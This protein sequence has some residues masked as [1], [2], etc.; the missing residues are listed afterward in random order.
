MSNAETQRR[1]VPISGGGSFRGGVH[2]TEYKELTENAAIKRLVPMKDLVFPVVPPM[3]APCD[4]ILVKPKQE[5][6]A[7]EKIADASAFVATP[8]HSSVNGAVKAIEYRLMPSG[9]MVRSIVITPE[10]LDY[11]PP[12]SR[13]IEEVLGMNKAAIVKEVREAGIVG[14]GG[15]AF[16]THVKLS[17]PKDRDIDVLIINGC[18]CEPYLTADYRIMLERSEDVVAGTRILMKALGVT[19]AIIAVEDNKPKALAELAAAVPA[20]EGIEVLRLKTL[21]PQGAEKNL[22]F[23]A[24]HRTVPTGGLP[25]DSGVVVQNVTTAVAVTDALLTGEPLLRKP[26]TITGL[27]LAEPGNYR[28]PIG[29]TIA[30]IME[31]LGGTGKGVNKI[32]FGGPMMGM[33]L[34]SIDVPVLKATSGV[35]FARPEDVHFYRDGTCIRCSKCVDHCPMNLVPTELAKAAKAVSID[36]LKRYHVMSCVECGCCAYDCPADIP[37]VHYIRQGKNIL[38]ETEAKN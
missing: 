18:E 20:G 9:K 24:L 22:I 32:I 27:A 34:A 36:T 3:G 15:A 25:M 10:S 11:T 12:L 1:P 33:A 2:V 35:I 38:K 21:Y 28:V 23:A 26:I 30:D 16:P 8:A 7:G 17:P 5:V 13:P 6:A 37:L 4:A 19:R 31:Q 14:L 29:M